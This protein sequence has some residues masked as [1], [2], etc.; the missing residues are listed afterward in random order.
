MGPLSR[1]GTLGSL[2]LLFLVPGVASPQAS[3]IL[4][5]VMERETGQAI[6]GATVVL[7]GQ[8]TAFLVVTDERG[9]FDFQGVGGGAYQVTVSHLAYGEHTREVSLAPDAQIALRILISLQAIELD[10]LV[11]EGLSDRDMERRSRG[12]MIQ[13]VTREEIEKAARTS[14]HLGDIL[15]QSVPGLRVY[16]TSL[17]GARVCIEFR[18]RRS[19]RFANGCQTPMVLLDG[20]R[21]YDPS[22]LYSTLDPS[23]IERIEVIPPAEAGLFYGSES[24][25]GVITIQTKVWRT[26][27]EQGTIPAHLRGGVYDWTLEVEPHS[28]KKVFLA[29]FAGNLVGVA[30]GMNIANRCVEFDELA[31]DLFASSCDQLPT[32]GAWA[33]LI[34]LPL[35]GSAMGAR[36]AGSTALS[37]GRLLPT[38]TAGA[39]ALLPGYS[40]VSASQ[41][42]VGSPSF[43]GG[44][45]LV[46]VGIPV[47]VTI[48]DRLFRKFRG[49]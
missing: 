28:W 14:N 1:K 26:D 15:R 9:L 37:R 20:V 47:A 33:T 34:S 30:A 45:F 13:E 41:Q 48:A 27:E 10:P 38:M 17:P 49:R 22:S 2:F 6:E 4:G 44:Q 39:I 16:D 43:R 7:E 46:L 40:L 25:F 8:D 19:I 31:T 23:S 11:V 21:M 36:Y 18:G 5:R 32:A 42:E 3:D 35:V 12:T 24:A 29:A